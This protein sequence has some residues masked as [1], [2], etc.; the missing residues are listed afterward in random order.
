MSR[1]IT[2]VDEFL[3]H[4]TTSAHRILD[5][6]LKAPDPRISAS[7][8]DILRNCAETYIGIKN[9]VVRPSPEKLTEL[10]D[11]FDTLIGKLEDAL[12]RVTDQV[13]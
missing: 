10:A 2:T 6:A 5:I 4:Y 1:P 3:A 7:I 8:M 12:A 9:T 11:E 13:N